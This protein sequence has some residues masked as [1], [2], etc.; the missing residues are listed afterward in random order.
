MRTIGNILWF[1][2]GGYAHGLVLVM[3]NENG[4]YLGF[5]LYAAYFLAGLEPEPCVKVGKRLVKQQHARHFDQR[6]G[7]C[8]ALLLAAGKLAGLAVHQFV[9]LHKLCRF[10]GALEH[11]FLAQLVR[12]LKILQREKYVLLN[13]KVRIKG[14]VL[15]HKANAP[16]FRRKAGNVVL[17]KEYLALGGLLQAAYH[18]KRCAFAAAG[19]TEQ[20]YQLSVGNGKVAVVYGYYLLARFLVAAGESLGH[21]AQFNFHRFRPRSFLVYFVYLGLPLFID[22]IVRCPLRHIPC[23]VLRAP[24]RNRLSFDFPCLPPRFEP[25]CRVCQRCCRLPR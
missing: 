18:I 6:A 21:V 11:F 2:F 15:E 5:A 10:V 7:Y 8:N 16:V 14:I 9:Y 17:A 13:G 1:I 25:E 24:G 23:A 12:P 20:A 4:G 19:R 3:G 22:P